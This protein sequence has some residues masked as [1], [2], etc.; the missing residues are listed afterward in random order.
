MLYA[1]RDFRVLETTLVG[2]VFDQFKLHP[3]WRIQYPLWN[4]L[5]EAFVESDILRQVQSGT[6]PI[7]LT[8]H[9]RA[10]DPNSVGQLI[11][12]PTALT[13]CA[14]EISEMGHTPTFEI[15]MIPLISDRTQREGMRP[16]CPPMTIRFSPENYKEEIK[17]GTAPI[18]MALDAIIEMSRSSQQTSLSS[19]NPAV[20][21]SDTR[22]AG[23]DQLRS[24]N[25]FLIA[26]R[27]AELMQGTG[28]SSIT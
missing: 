1:R 5:S 15:H 23:I 22:T 10:D 24:D 14:Q 27:E 3:D 7:H 11:E 28:P 25:A 2:S 8:Y 9:L 16:V 17:Q 4:L 26:R 12:L 6:D 21:S 19:T 20:T 18:S 13:R